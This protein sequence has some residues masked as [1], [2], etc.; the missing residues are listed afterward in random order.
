MSLLN[1]KPETPAGPQIERV[2]TAQTDTL[3]KFQPGTVDQLANELRVPKQ[4]FDVPKFE[5]EPAPVAPPPTDAD[6]KR[7]A[8]TAATQIIDFF[9]SS[10]SF[11]F[12]F[13]GKKDAKC[14]RL[15][16]GDKSVIRPHLTEY[17]KG[18]SVDIPPGFMLLF[19][20]VMV[21]MPILQRAIED[22]KEAKKGETGT[23]NNKETETIINT[24]PL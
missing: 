15:D 2:T 14:Y 17:L 8:A 9:D 10:A 12:S 4:P 7:E 16:A 19:V 13:V 21:Y 5:N 3:F 1:L 24:N 22:R 11:A 20:V 23:E 6:L 18:K